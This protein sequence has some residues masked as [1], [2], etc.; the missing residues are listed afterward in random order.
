MESIQRIMVVDDDP[1]INEL[2]KSYLEKEGY[3]VECYLN[4]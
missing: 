2:V 3:N 1:H 4:G